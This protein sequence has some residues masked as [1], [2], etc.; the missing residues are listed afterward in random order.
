LESNAKDPA[1]DMKLTEWKFMEPLKDPKVVTPVLLRV[2]LGKLSLQEM[3]QEF[4]R[5]K[6]IGIIQK[7]FLKC[8]MK[9][10]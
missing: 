5:L 4:N 3:G 1:D 10:T 7:A 9:D 8:L 2:I 6:T